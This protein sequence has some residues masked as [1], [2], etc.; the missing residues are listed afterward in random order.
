MYGLPHIS[1]QTDCLVFQQQII[2]SLVGEVTQKQNAF[3]ENRIKPNEYGVIQG[4]ETKNVLKSGP[5]STLKI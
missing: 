5:L 3:H 1:T 4:K 2:T